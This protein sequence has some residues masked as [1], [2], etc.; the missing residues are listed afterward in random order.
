[1]YFNHQ[2]RITGEKPPQPYL[3]LKRAEIIKR[4][5]AAELLRQAF[6]DTSEPPMQTAQSLHGAFGQSSD[7]KSRYSEPVRKWLLSSSEVEACIQRML[8]YTP[9]QVVLREELLTYVRFELVDEITKVTESSSFIQEELSTRLAV[10]G[11]LPM[12]GFPS[13]VRSLFNKKSS[14]KVDDMTVSD[15][16]LDHAIW[17][18]SPGAEIPKDKKIYTACGFTLLK[19]SAR[20]VVRDDDPLGDFLIFSKCLDPDCATIEIE[21]SNHCNVCE[22]ETEELHVYQ[23]KG[24][25]TLNHVRDYER[26]R[27]RGSPIMPPVLAFTPDYNGGLKFG[28][29]RLA[30]TSGKPIALINNN[31]GMGF[32]LYKHYNDVVVKDTELYRPDVHSLFD[33]IAAN[34]EPFEQNAAIGAVFKSDVLSVVL[35]GLQGVGNNGVLDTGSQRAAIP[36][37]T[38]FLEV[39]KQAAATY[40]DVDPGE[41]RTGR[42]HYRTPVCNTQQIFMADTLENGA[43]YVSEIFDVEVMKKFL[44]ERYREAE[45]EWNGSEHI[46]C[47]KSCPDC[48]RTYSNRFNHGLLDWRLALDMME[49]FLG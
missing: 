32:D 26:D 4:V 11:I 33:H 7:W 2:E 19:D 13:N 20:G 12:F 38:S 37:L 46:E 48:L 25:L 28:E 21:N 29:K 24:F 47:D 39:L 3:D 8:V 41:F 15:R 36:A 43:G 22:G 23:P 44:T 30:L 49:L 27:K 34:T 45:I 40:L 42:Q 9:C 6:L 16:A 35:Q 1:Y 14:G 31:Q 5:V 10:A 18:F 17:S